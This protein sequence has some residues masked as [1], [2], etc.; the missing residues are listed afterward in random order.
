MCLAWQ[1]ALAADTIIISGQIN[2]CY[3]FSHG[4]VRLS[5][6]LRP[7]KISLHS[8]L[9]PLDSFY[10]FTIAVPTNQFPFGAYAL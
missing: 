1:P 5:G 7:G 9:V 2:S 10:R 4:V 6:P 8:P 3:K